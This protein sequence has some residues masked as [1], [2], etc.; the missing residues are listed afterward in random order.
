MDEEARTPA[1]RLERALR[2]HEARKRA[3]AERAAQQAPESERLKA[4]RAQLEA[5]PQDE[6]RAVLDAAGMRQVS[7]APKPEEPLRGGGFVPRPNT[8]AIRW[9]AWLALPHV[10]LWQ[11]V[12]LSVG[13]NP[14]DE[15]RDDVGRAP[16]RFS[17]LP[18]AFFERLS[19]C[20][21]AL[22]LEGPIRPQGGLYGGM[23]QSPLCKVLLADVAA[24]LTLAGYELPEELREG[25][26]VS[27]PQGA[28]PLQR[29]P[30]QEQEILR[31][32]RE[33]K[34]DPRALP[35]PAPGLPGPKAA[36]RAAL[37]STGI[38]AGERVFDKAWERLRDSGD[39]ADKS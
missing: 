26:P 3:A 6:R 10:E 7:A 8:K 4:L 18:A 29:W 20:Q 22:S 11:A 19:H 15:L 9:P 30:Y 24:F 16:S 5:L 37:G 34:L 28:Q 2:E 14:G 35:K 21:K 27:A 12:A 25:L 36:A 1:D 13:V 32:L 31:V 39:I 17:R 38:W 33:L 23:L